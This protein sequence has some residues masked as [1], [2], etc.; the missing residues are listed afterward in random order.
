M[1]TMFAKKITVPIFNQDVNLICGNFQE[2]IEYLAHL[3]GKQF[4]EVDNVDGMCYNVG[5]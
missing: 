2:I 4:V 5:W 1:T 3:H